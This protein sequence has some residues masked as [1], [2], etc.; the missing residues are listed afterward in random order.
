M[1]VLKRKPGETI[2]IAG[3]IEVTILKVDA[4]QISVGVAAPAEIKVLRKELLAKPIAAEG[5][6]E[7]NEC[8][9]D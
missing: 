1:L 6:G 2:V 3:G 9:G 5:K 8:S 7:K 4:K